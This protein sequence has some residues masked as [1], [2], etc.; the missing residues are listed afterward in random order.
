M[1]NLN[2]VG[3]KVGSLYNHPFNYD[4]VLS[5]QIG[6]LIPIQCDEV[7]P[8][9]RWRENIHFLMRFAPMV[10]PAMAKMNVCFFSFFVPSR[11]LMPRNSQHS[12]WEKFI[13]SLTERKENIPELPSYYT[14]VPLEGETYT[15]NKEMLKERFSYGTLADYLDYPVRPIKT[16][17][18]IIGIE[19]DNLFNIPF[20]D[21]IRLDGF[22]AYQMVYNYWFR[23]DQI[24]PEI[25]FP[26][27]L[28]SVD[29]ANPANSS[30]VH[31]EE[32]DPTSDSDFFNFLDELFK[33]RDKNYERD[34]FTSSLP[35]P[36]YGEDVNLGNDSVAFSVGNSGAEFL[37]LHG[38]FYLSNNRSYQDG[39]SLFIDGGYYKPGTYSIGSGDGITLNKSVQQDPALF[40]FRYIHEPTAYADA[41]N[42][43]DNLSGSFALTVNEFRAKMQLQAVREAINRGGTMYIEIMNNVYDSIVPDARL[44]Q[45]VYLGG[46]KCPIQI[47]AVVQSS[48][49]TATTPL[50]TLAGKAQAAN[51]G[52]IFKSNQPFAEHGYVLTIACVA[53]RTGYVG[54]LPRKWSKH[55]PFDYYN[56]YFAHLG[57][58]VIQKKE[59][60]CDPWDGSGEWRDGFGYQ[61]RYNDYRHAISRA[62]GEM[63]GSKDYWHIYRYFDAPPSLSTDFIKMRK[64]DFDRLFEFETINGTSNEHF[65]MFVALDITKKSPVPKYGTP[66]N[67]I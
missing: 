60:Y 64:E 48:E 12:T 61:E 47:G 3:G 36:Q 1:S 58:E 63:R 34:Y 5:G 30:Y 55:D 59:L 26:L 51:G 33:L 28:E 7:L 38:E 9:E 8:R 11:I 25:T 16:V 62:H 54:G 35:S 24:E 45:P 41:S 37:P 18:G 49:T 65:D 22:L 52:M 56:K 31:N 17:N 44:Q 6:K 13:L 57:E 10:A 4:N 43:I 50:G 23:R 21:R 20:P 2:Y 29:L 40:E 19:D 46:I 32:W 39:T 67:F 27:S 53:P 42:L 15:A 66:Y 14:S